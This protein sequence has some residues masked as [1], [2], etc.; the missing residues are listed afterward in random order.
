MG[1]CRA[2]VVDDGA[3]IMMGYPITAGILFGTA[4]TLLIILGLILFD[5]S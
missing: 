1:R 2:R 3:Q 5:R 4:A